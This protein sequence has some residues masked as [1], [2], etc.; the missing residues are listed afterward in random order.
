MSQV[1]KFEDDLKEFKVKAYPYA[2]RSSINTSAFK[3]RE[4]AQG[5]IRNSMIQRNK[6]T[7]QS[8]QVEQTKTLKVSD[9]YAVVGSTAKYMRDQEFGYVK[10]KRGALGVSIATGYSAGQ[11]GAA[12]R[13]K[14]PKKPNTLQ[15]I[16]LAGRS[17]RGSSLK[18]KN[19]IA[20][21][22]AAKG[23]SKFIYLDLGRRK[24]IFKVIGG[25]SRPKIKMIHDLSNDSVTI[26]RNP[27]LYPAHV[28]VVK[29]MPKIYED[30]LL[31]QLKKFGILGY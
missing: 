21:K 12:Q 13:T 17:K 10:R 14:L 23:A 4:I 27:W 22:E 26:S 11:E 3:M 28:E 29:Y 24:G 15:A 25:S 18:Q 5:N 9:Q 31:F 6:F 19:L 30:A 8:V 2:S 16:R 20:I 7:I 1:K